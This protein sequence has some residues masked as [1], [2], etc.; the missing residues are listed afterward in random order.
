IPL[1]AHIMSKCPDA[2]DCLRDLILP[3]MQK[4]HDKVN[5]TLSFIGRP[6]DN[7]GVACKHGPEECLGNIIELCAQ[8]LYPDPKSFLGFTMCM[9]RDYRHIP[10]R[11]LVEDCALEHALDFGELNRCATKDDGGYGVGMLR[12]SV[13]RS[14]EA[15]VTKSC[16]VRL[17]NEIYCVRDDGQ[18]KDCPSGAN[19]NDLLVAI[20]KLY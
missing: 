8:E 3:T 10:Q 13:R 7:D 4:A 12:N 1:E 15:G 11:S 17:D 20:E 2:R 6:T 9:T 5:F 14:S 16:T 18:W 19:V